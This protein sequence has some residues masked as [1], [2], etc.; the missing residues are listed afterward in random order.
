MI[1]APGDPFCDEIGMRPELLE[2]MKK[3]HGLDQPIPTQFFNYIK[4]I[5]HGDLGRSIRFAGEPVTDI[6]KSGFPISLQLGLQAFLLALPLGTLIG[7]YSAYTG[8]KKSSTLSSLGLTIGISVPT[9]VAAALLQHFFSIVIPIFPVARWDSLL[10]TVLP[11][12]SLALIPTASIARIMRTSSMEIMNKEYVTYA[13]IKGLSEKKI[14]F[15]YILPNA[16]LPCLHY[17]GPTLANL[18][19]G[20]FAVERVYAI[21]GLG[22]WFVTAILTRDYPVIAGLTAFY[23]ILL[24]ATGFLI[25]LVTERSDSR[26]QENTP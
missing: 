5:C 14:A 23:S 19:F 11:T 24:F 18:L 9:F 26:L 25:Q 12:L 10:H 7:L 1:L 17:I 3:K 4:N 20:S 21:P 16:C 2:A 8:Q 6:I 22:Q 13:R 15:M